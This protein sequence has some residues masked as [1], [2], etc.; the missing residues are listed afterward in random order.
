MSAPLPPTVSI[1]YFSSPVMAGQSL[2]LIC[3]AVVQEGI[4]GNPTLMWTR[5]GVGDFIVPGS[6]LT[7]EPLLTSHGGVYTCTA[8]LTIPEARV[9]VSGVNATILYVQSKLLQS[10]LSTYAIIVVML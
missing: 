9:D 6:L 7:F 8:T 5:D 3:S 4:S 1:A 2:T 10:N